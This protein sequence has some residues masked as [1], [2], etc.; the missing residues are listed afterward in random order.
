MMVGVENAPSL[1]YASSLCGACFE[2][3]PVKIDIPEVLLHL[4]G[5]VV[6]HEQEHGTLADSLSQEALGMKMMSWIFASRSRYENAQR[7]GRIGQKLA[8]RDGTISRLPGMLSGW[9][10][11][12]DMNA[13]PPQ[14]F[15]EWWRGRS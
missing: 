11:M 8:A 4:R 2:V 14:T 9:T 6:R 15:R 1:P 5:Q 13:I 3:C 12:R 7:L 10:A